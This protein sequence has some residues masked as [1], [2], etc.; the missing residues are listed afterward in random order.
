MSP[1]AGLLKGMIDSMVASSDGWKCSVADYEWMIGAS[2]NDASAL[3]SICKLVACDATPRQPE[4]MYAI[5]LAAT[6][7]VG[8]KAALRFALTL[9]QR[10]SAKSHNVCS[11]VALTIQIAG[12]LRA[13]ADADCESRMVEITH[14]V[15][16]RYNP[17]PLWCA[18]IRSAQ[19][20]R[21]SSPEA[22][23]A[24]FKQWITYYV[25][26]HINPTSIQV[27]QYLAANAWPGDVASCVDDEKAVAQILAAMR[28]PT[29]ADESST[30]DVSIFARMAAE[31]EAEK[32]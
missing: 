29:D 4:E 24:D 25:Y 32:K 14:E 1:P 18:A 30:I 9:L 10:Y 17:D 31:E 16:F 8:P 7:A 20:V 11:T 19:L 3:D 5:L 27:L 26:P 23:N 6:T 22:E 2:A 28:T 13:A 15:V 12:K 21:W